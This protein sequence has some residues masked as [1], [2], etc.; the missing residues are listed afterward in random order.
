MSS[1]ASRAV[2]IQPGNEPH[3]AVVIVGA[4]PTG[5]TLANL[6]GA[7]GVRTLLVERGSDVVD[8]PRAVSIDDE[9][10]RTLQAAGVVD[11]VLEQVVMGYG[12]WY[13]S[14]RGKEFARVEPNACEYGF[15]KRNAF[16]QQILVAQLRDNLKRFE[17]VSLKFD[18]ESVAF[19]DY[20][21]GVRLQLSHAGEVKP[22]R[23]DWLVACD[24][25]RSG[26]REQL[27][28]VLAGRT[29]GKR[30]L[31]VDLIGR[32]SPF[33]HT[34]TFCD[35]ARP[36][37]RLPGPNGTLRYEFMLHDHESAEDV[38]DEPL[39]RQWIRAR[40]PRD[41]PLPI[42][43]KVVY[44]FHARVAEHWKRGRVFLA[45]D[46]AHLTPPFAGQGM[47]SGVRDAANLSWKLAAVVHGRLGEP[48]LDSYE[49][50]RRP[51]AW[52]LIRMAMRIGRFMQPT[53][54]TSAIL[55]QATL[56]LVSTY[57][58]VRDYILHLRFKPKP[59]FGSGFFSAGHARRA[60]V[61]AGQLLPQPWVEL[62]HGE[63]VRLDDV[64]GTGFAMLMLPGAGSIEFGRI[65][66][67]AGVPYRR[68][69]IIPRIDDFIEE[70]E[71]GC[72]DA[73]I[74]D[75]AGVLED[76]MRSVGA[77]VMF[78]RPDR[79]VLGY[80]K[81]GDPDS[82]AALG[83]LFGRFVYATRPMMSA[84]SPEASGTVAPADEEMADKID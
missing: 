13:Y 46:A 36:A 31:I 2:A 39:V 33:R 35:P 14:W 73:V 68:V 60:S 3:Y 80:A 62:Y 48:L 63:R 47:N 45:G 54:V 52:A 74:R 26:I 22:V 9:S 77:D 49:E 17:H 76:I 25:G 23:C 65:F 44:T 32:T 34:K 51:H 55:M 81:E 37:I 28:I 8:E 57:R 24:G 6:L 18:H 1:P 38:L 42:A 53:S 67:G 84:A 11:S 5:L 15:P 75:D 4:G 78:V 79:Y 82:I 7:Y 72:T 27:G 16:R 30:W 58:P 40:D 21:D 61:P 10:L 83:Q 29:Y 12:T 50:E 56:R 20:G 19:T 71:A 59:R 66:E 43:R 64:L 70:P 69:R 41:A